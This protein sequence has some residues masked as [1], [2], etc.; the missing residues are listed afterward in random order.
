MLSLTYQQV[1]DAVD[2][3]LSAGAT[4]AMENSS[5]PFSFDPEFSIPAYFFD[6][7]FLDNADLSDPQAT[8]R[9]QPD[10]DPLRKRI[11]LPEDSQGYR[12]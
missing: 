5:M 1:H 10:S 8:E 2:L 9:R 7:D 6:K 3:Q 11:R 12:C 4:T